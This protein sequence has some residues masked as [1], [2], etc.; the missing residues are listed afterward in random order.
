ML[1]AVKTGNTA[2]WDLAAAYADSLFHTKNIK[3]FAEDVKKA[4]NGSLNIKVHPGGALIKKNKD[5]RNAVRSNQIQAAEFLGAWLSNEEQIWAVDTLPFTATSYEAAM[6]LWQASKPAIEK[7]LDKQGLKLLFAVPWPPQ[8]LYSV[9]EIKSIDNLK[10][11]KFRT[12]SPFTSRFAMLAGAAGTEIQPPLATAF[13][14]GRV[15][16]MIT[17]SSFGVANKAWDY[18]EYFYDVQAWL[19]KNFIVVSKRALAKLDDA[20][21]KVVLEAAAT[22]ETRGWQMSADSNSAA[23]KALADNN[24]QVVAPSP[25]LVD[26]FKTIGKT[27][28]DEW[29]EKAGSAGKAILDSYTSM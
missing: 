22:A 20:T 24:M 17:S 15:E 28:G 13:Q 2:D 10:G 26:G 7:A 19:P 29:A 14:T 25:E 9:K 5:N 16:A 8:G 27:M 23:K 3:L 21:Q 12:Y 18:L 4:S 11:M 6:K 1:G